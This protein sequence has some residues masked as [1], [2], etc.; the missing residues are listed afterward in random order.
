MG[1]VIVAR[2]KIMNIPIKRIFLMLGAECNLQCKYCLQHDM[3]K[4]SNNKVSPSVIEWIKRQRRY[5]SQPMTITFYGGEPLVYWGAIVD[6]VKQLQGQIK[7]NIITNGKLMDEKKADFCNDNNI[8]VAVSYDGKNVIATRGYD[9]LSDN[10]Y[11]LTINSLSLSAV[12]SSYTYPKDFLDTLEPFFN[13]YRH[14]HRGYPKLNIDTI[15][16]FGNCKD[17]RKMDLAKI[18]S[19][20]TDI[21]KSSNVVY[22]T[23]SNELLSRCSYSQ[24]KQEYAACGNGIRVWNVDTKGNVYRCHNCGEKLGTINDNPAT[25]LIRA[26]KKDPTTSNYQNKC[27]SCSVYSLCKCGCPLIDKAGRDS[28]YCDIRRAYYKPVIDFFNEQDE[29]GR[30]IIIK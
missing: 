8:G 27:G 3:V 14:F 13:S 17:L 2:I 21:L 7:F 24:T 12:L 18:S 22:R 28:Y 19:Q 23:M 26:S 11:I 25:I 10:P 29:V 4:S 20:M 6:V 1:S 9:V 16:D 15:M 30:E 5:Q